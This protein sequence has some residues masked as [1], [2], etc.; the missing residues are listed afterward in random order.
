MKEPKINTYT[1]LFNEGIYNGLYER[2]GELSDDQEK[3]QDGTYFHRKGDREVIILYGNEMEGIRVTIKRWG[4][5]SR[6]V[7]GALK[8]N[9]LTKERLHSNSNGLE[10]AV[11]GDP[12]IHPFDSTQTQ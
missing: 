2:L 5:A 10:L 12:E 4:S 8:G 3:K 9:G 7:L 1:R 6:E 11:G